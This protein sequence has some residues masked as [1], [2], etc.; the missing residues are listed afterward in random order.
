MRNKIGLSIFVVGFLGLC[1]GIMMLDSMDI[2][3][4]LVVIVIG[5][6]VSAVGYLMTDMEEVI[7][8]TGYQKV[9]ESKEIIARKARNR[10]KTWEAWIATK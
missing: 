8:G 9:K 5:F 2:T 10:Q 4:P 1:G 6:L 7:E 3:I